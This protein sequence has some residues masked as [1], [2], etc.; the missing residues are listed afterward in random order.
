MDKILFF[1]YLK[2][3]KVTHGY[4]KSCVEPTRKVNKT[5]D[6]KLKFKFIAF[7]IIVYNCR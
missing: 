5:I 7:Y 1:Y 4:F 2:Q 6:K 3:I